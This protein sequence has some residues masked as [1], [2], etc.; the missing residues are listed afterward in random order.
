[1]RFDRLA[2]FERFTPQNELDDSG[3]TW[4]EM[5]RA[6]VGVTPFTARELLNSNQIEQNETHRV[7]MHWVNGLLPSDRLRFLKNELPYPDDLERE[8][9]Y[10]TLNID[11]VMNTQE[12]NRELELLCTEVV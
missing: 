8:E 9:N 4:S 6:W 3:G 11:S 1:M 7:R 2:I 10:R 12:Q 5:F